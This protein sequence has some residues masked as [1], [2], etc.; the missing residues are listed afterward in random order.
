MVRHIGVHRANHGDVIDVFGDVR[1]QFTHLDSALAVF[2][3]F[4]WRLKSG[5]GPPL[6]LQIIHRQWLAMQS[7]QLWFWIECIDVRWPAIGENVNDPLRF[8]RK[9]GRTW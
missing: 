2:R 4:E 8:G 5:A 3:K 9:L 6:G 1:E 7:R